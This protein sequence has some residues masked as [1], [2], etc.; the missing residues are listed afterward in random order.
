MPTDYRKH[1]LHVVLQR[2]GPGHGI[3]TLFVGRGQ[4]VALP[5]STLEGNCDE[6]A[7]P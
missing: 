3:L 1:P 4:R 2:D 7:L 5:P 6:R